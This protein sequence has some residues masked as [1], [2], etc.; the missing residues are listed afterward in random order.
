M[1]FATAYLDS[2]F[3][4]SS[5]FGRLVDKIADKMITLQAEVPFQAI[6]FRGASGA[7]MAYPI[8]AQLNIPLIYVR[9]PREQSHGD[10]IE[11]TNREITKYIIV[12][13]FIE[14]GKTIKDIIKAIDD[15]ADRYYDLHCPIKCVGIVLYA[16][17]DPDSEFHKDFTKHGGTKIPIYYWGV[18]PRC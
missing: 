9:K 14:T 12:D 8:S 4:S 2:V 11:G 15:A 13:D 16:E 17:Q 5:K 7:A 10:N 18:K 1:R 3:E 6:A